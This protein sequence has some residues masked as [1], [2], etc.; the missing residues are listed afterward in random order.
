[1][2]VRIYQRQLNSGADGYG[3][4]FLAEDSASYRAKFVEKNPDVALFSSFYAFNGANL[5]GN[6][7][8]I[9]GSSS[10]YADWIV[11]DI[12]A[13]SEPS[14][15]LECARAFNEHLKS[16][17]VPSKHLLYAFSGKKGYNVYIPTALV[18]GYAPGSKLYKQITHFIQSITEA[19]TDKYGLDMIATKGDSDQAK[20]VVDLSLGAKV[21]QVVRIIG[22][23]HLS[24]GKYKIALSADSLER[25]DHQDI[26]EYASNPV[27]LVD[28]FEPPKQSGYAVETLA[29]YWLRAEEAY[30]VDK[31]E[32]RGKQE[33]YRNCIKQTLEKGA[34]S[35]RNETAYTLAAHFN[36]MGLPSQSIE[37]L[38][39]DWMRRGDSRDWR[40]DETRKVV[41]SATKRYGGLSCMTMRNNL[42]TSYCMDCP[43]FKKAEDDS[44]GTYATPTVLS[45]M[46]AKEIA[47]REGSGWVWGN[48]LDKFAKR[49][50]LPGN[51]IGILGA[52]GSGKT[53]TAE[54]MMYMNAPLG[55]KQGFASLEM[56]PLDMQKKFIA[57]VTGES[58]EDKIELDIA[59]FARGE[60]APL[61]EAFQSYYGSN[62]IYWQGTPSKENIRKLI[63]ENDLDIIYIDY[64]Q[65]LYSSM[66]A[67]TEYEANNEISEFAKEL[68]KEF[69]VVVVFL[70]QPVGSLEPGQRPKQTDIRNKGG[71]IDALDYIIGIYNKPGDYP[72]DRRLTPCKARFSSLGSYAHGD[73]AV[74]IDFEK[75]RVL[76]DTACFVGCGKE[77][78]TYDMRVSEF[79]DAQSVKDFIVGEE[80][81]QA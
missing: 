68:R 30:K 13:P 2:K 34:D 39:N 55:A 42:G 71:M 16:L 22:S 33:E 18:P 35:F 10:L 52:A 63:S 77:D 76:S 59:A 67:N 24:T 61:T 12:D 69:N 81:D 49:K 4:T 17:G 73:I 46:S 38:I 26:L 14:Y 32:S 74:T 20:A 7:D 78:S 70:I 23:K 43:I 37:I 53:L 29:Q 3:A 56:G 27:N 65:L 57:Q 40:E 31:W 11:L 44:K 41:A 66:S 48:G 50:I 62:L 28:G 75:Q 58:D 47:S 64:L 6:P 80:D 1:M 45:R 79:E 72:N 60:Y 54:Q 9:N 15:A 5:R 19:V 51:I 36:E 25:L 21:K 8:N